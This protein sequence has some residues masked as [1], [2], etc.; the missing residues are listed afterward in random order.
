MLW[1]RILGGIWTALKWSWPYLRTG[2][3]WAG[4]LT[5]HTLVM[6]TLWENA[7]SRLDTMVT[8]YT[9]QTINFSPLSLVNSLFP[10]AECLTMLASYTVLVGVSNAVRITKAFIDAKKT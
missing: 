4:V 3:V 7:F 6:K 10:L 1:G 8:G 9:A 5:A 2:L